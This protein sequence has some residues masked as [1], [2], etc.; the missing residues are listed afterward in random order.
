[1]T[2]HKKQTWLAAL[3]LVVILLGFSHLREPAVTTSGVDDQTAA[4]TEEASSFEP[5]IPSDGFQKTE[6]S[7]IGSGSGQPTSR[8]SAGTAGSTKDSRSGG[9]L[10]AG[11]KGTGHEIAGP[12]VFYTDQ[13]DD[14]YGYEMSP[15]AGLSQRAF[16]ILRVDWAPVSYVDEDRPGGYSTSITVAGAARDDGWYVSYG[17]F[18][19][20][21]GESCQLYH[22]LTPGAMAYANAFCDSNDG[23]RYVGRVEG[24]RVSSTPTGDGG[25]VLI[26]TF[27]NRAILPKLQAAGRTLYALS[28]FT[29]PGEG[30]PEPTDGFR[31][32]LEQLD[33]AS[34]FATYRL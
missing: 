17:L 27:D 8:N 34:S 30:G 31:C 10:G 23:R 16:D 21:A 1:M 4:G 19:P 28:A 26:A 32:G 15:N 24:G 12:P 22:I 20:G 6:G 7:S 5:E 2:L 9:S 13:A 33:Q 11:T 25:T 3:A 18:R 29:C 14:A